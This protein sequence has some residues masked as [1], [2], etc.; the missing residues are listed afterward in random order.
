MPVLVL[1]IIGGFP[2]VFVGGRTGAVHEG[3][4]K[5][6]ENVSDFERQYGKSGDAAKTRKEA[7][8]VREQGSK[9]VLLGFLQAI[10]GVAGGVYAFR[11][12]N[13]TACVE[14]GGRRIKRLSVAG[15][16][17][18]VAAV[19]SIHNTFAFITAGVLNGVAG[20]ITVLHSRNLSPPPETDTRLRY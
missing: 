18:L 11:R 7:A 8:E 10:L 15:I 2:S 12:Y 1:T 13:S 6:G 3:V 17:I 5:F 20:A 14:V 9:Y 4:A 19:I 16:A